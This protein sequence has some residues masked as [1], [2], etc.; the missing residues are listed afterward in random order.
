VQWD[1]DHLRRQ[2]DESPRGQVSAGLG[3]GEHGPAKTRADGRV[4]VGSSRDLVH[5]RRAVHTVP[6]EQFVLEVILVVE[7]DDRHRGPVGRLPAR[8]PF[9]LLLPP[10]GDHGSGG[11]EVA[12]RAKLVDAAT[13]HGGRVAGDRREHVATA[14]QLLGVRL[15][16]HAQL[17]R[18]AVPSRHFGEYVA[19]PAAERVGVDRHGE[20]DR[21]RR[22]DGL[23]RLGVQQPGLPAQADEPLAVR[24]G[25]AWGA[26][27]DQYLT[28]RGL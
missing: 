14:Q 13:L 16:L 17:D 3:L 6:A 26:P 8:L 5:D 2:A 25:A 11:G 7:D 18:G 21:G 1:F 27:A 4:E 23:S 19:E 28:R 22:R 15:V 20:V 10:A 12:K 24:C 9:P